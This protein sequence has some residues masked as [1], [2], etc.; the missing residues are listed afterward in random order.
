M[1]CYNMLYGAIFLSWYSITLRMNVIVCVTES[2][3]SMEALKKSAKYAEKN[4][5]PLHI[6]HGLQQNI[7]ELN[8]SVV[9]EDR[10]SAYERGQ[11]LMQNMKD[12]IQNVDIT[13]E[14]HVL[15][16]KYNPTEQIL[17]Y[18]EDISVNR[19]FLGNRGLGTK[20]RSV[21]SFSEKMV[22]KTDIPTTVIEKNNDGFETIQYSE[23]QNR[24]V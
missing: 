17:Q 9:H 23:T 11:E 8:G 15:D 13:I 2:E 21:G 18:L 1:L 20:H 24:S 19:I 6:L 12:Q 5:L 3:E 14:T 16:S 7:N 10:D 4:D 22:N